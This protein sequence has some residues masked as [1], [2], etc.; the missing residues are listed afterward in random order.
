MIK[1]VF[2]FCFVAVGLIVLAPFLL[3]LALLVRVKHGSPVLF[4]QRRIG[5]N[6]RPFD[7]FKF[8]SMSNEWDTDGNLL[9]D[10]QRLTK[11]GAFLRKNSLDELPELINI[12]RGEMSLVGPRPLLP[13]YLPF[14]TERERLRHTVRPGLTGLAQTSGR[15]MLGWDDRLELD[16]KYVENYSIGFDLRLLAKTIWKVLRREGITVVTSQEGNLSVERSF[17]FTSDTEPI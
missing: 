12:L 15:N 5:L 1:R 10:E 17:I 16:A 8:R 14:Y 3:C 7:I 13:E 11:F 9:P 4:R 6:E 2:D